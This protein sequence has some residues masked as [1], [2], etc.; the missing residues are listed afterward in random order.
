MNEWE[1]KLAS[2]E[3]LV[4]EQIHNLRAQNDQLTVEVQELK[5][6]TRVYDNE[7]VSLRKKVEQLV[8]T[9]GE[10]KAISNEDK[11]SIPNNCAALSQIGYR[12]SGL[13]MVQAATNKIHTV[14][15]EI[16]NLNGAIRKKKI[17]RNN[18]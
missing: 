6:Q 17:R 14:Y 2:M 18:W 16:N 11:A 13:Y 8:S 15:C 1:S 12:N 5:A 7:N 4:R 3:L 10:S 9:Q